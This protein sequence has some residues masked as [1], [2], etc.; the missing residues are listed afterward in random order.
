MPINPLKHAVAPA[1]ALFFVLSCGQQS[2]AQSVEPAKDPAQQTRPT[3][4]VPTHD[5]TVKVAVR[6]TLYCAGYI[7]YQ[8]FGKLPEIVGAEE[9][10]EQR[11]FTD[12]E[13]VYVNQ[14]SQQ[15][16][17]V[18]DRFQIIRPRGE[19]KHVHRQKKGF[20]GVFVQE[21]GMLEVFKVN[22]NTSAAQ[23]TFSCETILL[24][25]LLTKA[26]YRESPIVRSDLALDR[27]AD[28]TNKQNGRVMMAR[29]GRELL[30]RNDIVYI[31]LGSE[32]KVAPGDYLTIYRP[33]GTGTVTRVDNEENARGRSIGFSSDR[34]RGG[35]FSTQGQRA[36]D[37][38]ALVDNE[39]FYRFRP[40]TTKEIKRD[41]PKMPR[42]IVG[43]MVII[44]V[45]TRT[46][47]AVITRVTSEVHTGD[48]VEIQ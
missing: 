21:V 7:K 12:G 15:G 37:S 5:E 14:G 43:E 30:T 2:Q 45:Q 36:K 17:K 19:V 38:T 28:P 18:G 31:D 42:K 27:F 34:F 35:G 47:T 11:N 26:P 23:I 41:R 4:V 3:V 25:D 39:G 46:A 10:Q 13:V 1:L 40:I 16:I 22:E 32:D 8:R 24:G 44:D 9:E 48:W 6:S 20:L 33:L 29:D